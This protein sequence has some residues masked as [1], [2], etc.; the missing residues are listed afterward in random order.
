MPGYLPEQMLDSD[1]NMSPLVNVPL[2]NCP[3]ECCNQGAAKQITN[4]GKQICNA[5]KRGID[6]QELARD[7]EADIEVQAYRTATTGLKV[8]DVPYSNGQF[9]VLC[10]TSLGRSRPV[11]PT[12][13]RRRIFDITHSLAHPGA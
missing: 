10:D 3:N 6:Y 8:E 13:W 4:S 11:I 9:T 5:V 7:Q 12:N 2:V 1:D